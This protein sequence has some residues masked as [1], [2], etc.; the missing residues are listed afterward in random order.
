MIS[1]V[2]D[3]VLHQVHQTQPRSTKGEHFRQALIVHAIY[4]LRLLRLDF[5]PLRLQNIDVW[6]FL[7]TEEGIAFRLQV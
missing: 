5:Y 3:D 2:V 1:G 4:E 6:K 7:R